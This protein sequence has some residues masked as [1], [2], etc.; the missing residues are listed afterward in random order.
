M[1]IALDCRS[2]FQGMG[3]IGRYTWSLLHQF[4]EIGKRHEFVCYF[5]H[6]PP[7]APL[8]L[9]DNVSVRVFEAGMI[10]E[11]L[12]QLILPSLLEEDEID[13]Y[14][15]PTFSIPSIH[16][17]TK[18]VSTV[19][20]V[21][22]H[23]HPERVEPRLRQYLDAATRR[24]CRGADRLITVSEFSKG[25]I[26]EAY[27][28]DA[29]KL[30]VIHN[31]VH[32]PRVSP[33]TSF[34]RSLADLGLTPGGYVLYVGSIERK[35]NI[36]VLLDAFAI[37][38]DS[39]E[40]RGL[41]LVLAGTHVPVDLELGARLRQASSKGDV[42]LPGHVADEV[43]ESLYAAASAFVYP[44]LYE[45]FG[46]PPLEAMLRG[47]PTIVAGTSSLPEVVGDAALI[48]DPDDASGLSAAI[49]SVVRDGMLRSD[50]VRKGRLRAAEFTWRRS[51]ERH[52]AL[53]EKVARS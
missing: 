22:F 39:V 8:S 40:F 36:G 50:L 23:R 42:L 2:A 31:G 29:S 43:L 45:G 34:H 7:P 53:Y 15:N 32:S 25:E 35:K 1:R 37:L 30:E 41:K 20:D 14:H 4:A 44:S 51:A 3:G 26:A 21:V 18:L 19:H 27:S 6:L 28:V 9:A 49:A 11:R 10:D 47:V 24:A 46:L 16:G 52:L 5:T 12:D 48:V 33:G 13:L 38:T 17:Q